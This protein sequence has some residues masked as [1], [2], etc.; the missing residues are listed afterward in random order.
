MDTTTMVIVA[1]LLV[2]GGL[3]AFYYYRKRNLVKLFNEVYMASMQAPKK[4]KKSFLLLMFKESV[5][6]SKKNPSGMDKL[7]NPK[8]LQVQL[9]QMSTILKD[10]SKVQDKKM[11]Q[12]LHLLDDYLKW[13]N[14][15]TAEKKQANQ[16]KAS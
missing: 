9:V 2:I 13:E 5:A 1:V 14:A 3:T 4:Q 16:S 10:P 12:A 8:Y 6:Y 11:K 15:R 7:N